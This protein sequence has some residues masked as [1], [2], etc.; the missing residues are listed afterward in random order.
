AEPFAMD[1]MLGTLHLDSF[2]LEPGSIDRR[3]SVKSVAAHSLYEREHP[4]VHG[5]PGHELDLSACKFTS[6]GDRQV[7]VEAARPKPTPGYDIKLEVARRMAYRSVSI[8]GLRCPTMIARIDAIL[9]QARRNALQ[10]FAPAELKIG[11]HVYGRDGVM[12]QLEPS[13]NDLSHEL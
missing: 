1:V 8:A 12:Q 9:E 11:F 13:R 6:I 5:G 7:R 2:V 3:A 10:Y 4:Y